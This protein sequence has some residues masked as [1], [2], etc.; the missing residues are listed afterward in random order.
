[1][2]GRGITF[3]G[4]ES[5][6]YSK[7]IWEVRELLPREVKINIETSIHVE[8]EKLDDVIHFVDSMIIDV[9]TLV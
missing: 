8:R 2:S 3:G 9:K 6:L 4:G 7:E 5:L 1:M